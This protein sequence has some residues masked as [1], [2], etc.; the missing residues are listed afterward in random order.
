FFVD[1]HRSEDAQVDVPAADHGERIG[2]GEIRSAWHLG[3]GFFARIDQVSIFL[4]FDRIR[5][6]T[7]HAVLALQHHMNPGWDIIGDQC[8]HANTEIDIEAITQLAGNA[9]DDAFAF[10]DIFSWF[11]HSWLNRQVS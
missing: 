2:A 1:L 4:P 10:F 8:R 3:H 5:A 9:L 7:E 11:A 6:N